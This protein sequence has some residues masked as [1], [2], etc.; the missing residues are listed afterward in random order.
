MFLH[1]IDGEM[2]AQEVNE[3]RRLPSPSSEEHKAPRREDKY[4]AMQGRDKGGAE[5][6]SFQAPKQHPGDPV[7]PGRRRGGS[8]RTESTGT[9]I[10]LG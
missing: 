5:N 1:H 10:P 6:R 8:S 2:E 9:G 7:G 4:T 3:L